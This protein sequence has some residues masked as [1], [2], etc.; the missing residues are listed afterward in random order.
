MII[1]GLT[2][3]FN[4]EFDFNIVSILLAGGT[5]VLNRTV[6]TTAGIHVFKDYFG[7]M[8]GIFYCKV[9][10]FTDKHASNM[11]CH[12]ESKHYSPGYSCPH[13]GRVFNIQNT[14]RR[15]IKMQNCQFETA[16]DA[17]PSVDP[18]IN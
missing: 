9:C 17:A 10:G 7:K 4:S 16:T 1:F 11:K 8:D 14:L 18:F 13:C 3:V 12:I 6:S 5:L 15:H 2:L